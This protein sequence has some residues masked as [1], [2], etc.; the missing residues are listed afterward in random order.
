MLAGDLLEWQPDGQV[1]R[2]RISQ[3][4][5]MIRP[6]ARPG[7]VIAVERGLALTDGD[8]L[9]WPSRKLPELSRLRRDVWVVAASGREAGR[10]TVGWRRR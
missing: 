5:A 2:Q 9:G 4:A 8:D 10:G 1:R 6:R 7:V 3:V